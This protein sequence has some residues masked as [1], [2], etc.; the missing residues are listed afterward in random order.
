[1]TRPFT[2]WH[3]TAILVAFFGVI[4]AVNVTMATLATRTFGGKV[5]ENSYVASQQFNRWLTEAKAQDALGWNE[6]AALDGR[7]RV[8]LS[9]SSSGRP[10]AA[11]LVTG[12]AR[13]PLG[14]ERDVPLRFLSAGPGRW[15]SDAA[16]PAGRWYV[17][18]HVASG[19][20]DAR[21]VETLR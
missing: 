8:V 18:L 1:M 4:V 9:L 19:A 10:L 11:K 13:H 15:E 12:F 2:G 20:H 3:M 21:F 17:H 6:K 7:R 16:L 14:R 5:V